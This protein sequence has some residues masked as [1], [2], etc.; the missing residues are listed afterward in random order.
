MIFVE[1]EIVRIGNDQILNNLKEGVVILD[2]TSENVLFVNTAAKQFSVKA[3]ESF[4]MSVAGAAEKID[5][6]AM[7]F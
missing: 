5:I 6:N 1:S 2:K 4:N 3:N 7:C